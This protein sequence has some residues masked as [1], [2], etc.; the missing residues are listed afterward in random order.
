MSSNGFLVVLTPEGLK[1]ADV[2]TYA[3]HWGWEANQN[4]QKQIINNFLNAIQQELVTI[5]NSQKQLYYNLSAEEFKNICEQV[6]FGKKVIT[7]DDIFNELAELEEY[8]KK[9]QKKSNMRANIKNFSKELEQARKQE[10]AVQKGI[11]SLLAAGRIDINDVPSIIVKLKKLSKQRELTENNI[12][13]IINDNISQLLD[14]DQKI[15]Q[16]QYDKLLQ[17]VDHYRAAP[18]FKVTN[19]KIEITNLG[20]DSSEDYAKRMEDIIK[21]IKQQEKIKQN[22]SKKKK[23]EVA[24]KIRRHYIRRGKEMQ[25]GLATSNMANFELQKLIDELTLITKNSSSAKSEE[26]VREIVRT[27]II[28]LI[29]DYISAP[30]AREVSGVYSFKANSDK[31]IYGYVSEELQATIEVELNDIKGNIIETVAQVIGSDKAREIKIPLRKVTAKYSHEVNFPS[32]ELA[33]EEPPKTFEYTQIITAH[34]QDKGDVVYQLKNILQNET[35]KTNN[36]Y[37]AFSDKFRYFEALKDQAI[38][39]G[40]EKASNLVSSYDLFKN[41]PNAHSILF[42]LLNWHSVS[43]LSNSYQKVEDSIKQAINTQILDF[44]FNRKNLLTNIA[45]SFSEQVGSIDDNNT[46]YVFRLGANAFIPTY[47][48][49]ESILIQMNNIMTISE[50]VS[51]TISQ[52]SLGTGEELYNQALSLYP[53]NDEKT[54]SQAR[55]NYVAEQVASSIQIRTSI[56]FDQLMQ[57]FTPKI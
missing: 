43:Y 22:S 6:S 4:D 51:T 3:T 13:Q 30:S 32:L 48:L 57:L 26:Q 5:I 54:N 55:W 56:H 45:E 33:G 12:N 1:R 39:G 7:L 23:K 18:G 14:Q 9:H 20:N 52:S 36:M 16:V 15:N 19:G 11:A 25:T 50:I 24:E 10:L 34:E 41:T 42:A 38:I 40:D 28:N 31:G 46:L 53:S 37:I 27:S 47:Q 2:Q 44:A 49:L 29:D 17:L 21:K 35:N 8:Q